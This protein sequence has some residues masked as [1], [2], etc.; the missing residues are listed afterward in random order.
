MKPTNKTEKGTQN[1]NAHRFD[2]YGHCEG[3][4]MHFTASASLVCPVIKQVNK[5]NTK[6]RK[7]ERKNKYAMRGLTDSLGMWRSLRLAFAGASL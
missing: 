6:Q 2:E 1:M 3:C 7:A 5:T 4:E